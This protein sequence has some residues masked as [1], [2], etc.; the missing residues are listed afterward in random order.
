MGTRFARGPRKAGDMT[1]L[2]DEAVV[3]YEDPRWVPILPSR[4]VAEYDGEV[5]GS[6]DRTRRGR[7]LTTNRHG[8][9]IGTFRTLDQA[10]Q[11][12][13]QSNSATTFQRLDQSRL[14]LFGGL[15]MLAVTV[16]V[17][18]FGLSMLFTH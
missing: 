11:R 2:T 10:R 16:A 13:V 14:L 5:A 7:Y 6:I 15:G 17:A 3:P 1:T 18:A 8:R 12:L 9:K 4:W